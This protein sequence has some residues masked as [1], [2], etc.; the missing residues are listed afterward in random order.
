MRKLFVAALAVFGFGLIPPSARAD[1]APPVPPVK[2]VKFVVEVDEKAKAPKIIV[3]Q[4]LTTVRLRPRPIPGPPKANP[5]AKDDKEELTYLEVES[6]V[7]APTEPT[8]KNRDHLMIAGVALALSLGLGG[9]WLVRRQ[10]RNATRGLALLIAAGGTLG[11]STLVWANAPP[12]PIKPP[13]AKE[14]FVLPIA[15]DGKVNLEV[16]VGGDT[17]RL[18]LDKDTYDKLKEKPK[19]PERK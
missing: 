14:V 10:G 3:P 7:A 8:P 16:T 12:P 17:I 4:N 9:L 15:F 11:I 1:L 2:E 13:P 6:D 5:P 19:E 18:V